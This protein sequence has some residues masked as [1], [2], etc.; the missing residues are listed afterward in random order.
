MLYERI[1]KR[2]MPVQFPALCVVRQNSSSQKT[3]TIY[4]RLK[5]MLRRVAILSNRGTPVP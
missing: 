5:T 4:M 3:R 2:K 1:T